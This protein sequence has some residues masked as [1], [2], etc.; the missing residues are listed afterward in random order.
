MIQVFVFYVSTVVSA[1]VGRVRACW[2]ARMH[3]VLSSFFALSSCD[4]CGVPAR[5]C[6]VFAA[7]RFD[8]HSIALVLCRRSPEQ[9]ESTACCQEGYECVGLGENMCYWQVRNGLLYF[10]L[11]RFALF[12]PIVACAVPLVAD[13]AESE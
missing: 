13:H 6:F 1:V 8:R 7:S 10:T 12:S 5:K 2:T 9:C 11:V 4:S 3:E